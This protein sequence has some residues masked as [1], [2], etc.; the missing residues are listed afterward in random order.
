MT[1]SDFPSQIQ[2]QKYLDFANELGGCA[3]SIALEYFRRPTTKWTKPDHT[4]VTEVD[5][6]IENHLR[7]MI[8]S[9]Y[10]QHGVIGEEH[11]VVNNNA[12]LR[13]CIDP[14]DGTKSFVYGVPTF[15]TL[16]ALTFQTRPIVGVIEHPALN[17]RWCGA[18]GIQST[19]QG[20]ICKT[21][22]QDSLSDSVVYATSPDMF[23]EKERGVFDK[24]SSAVKLR[25]FGVDCH[26]YSL[27]ASG[28]ID[29]VME[30]DMKPYDMMALVPVVE[31]A[32]GVMTD[33]SGQA[34]T[35]ESGPQVLAAANSRLHRKC[36][37]EI[38]S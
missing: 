5:L 4:P 34:L 38:H 36:I 3:R 30:S 18:S 16:I 24:L 11:G 31:N 1:T 27:L 2:I 12:Q 17:E 15:G 25:Q 22:D 37:D 32:G 28:H 33:W 29:I 10:P 19:W 26:A 13:W 20:Q 9:H 7:D 6:K 23:S 21:N 8:G 14:I 35:T